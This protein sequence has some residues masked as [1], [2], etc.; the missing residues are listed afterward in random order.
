MSLE[1]LHMSG[2]KRVVH[3]R[4]PGVPFRQN[5]CFGT[6]CPGGV[7]FYIDSRTCD[8]ESVP[9]ESFIIIILFRSYYLSCANAFGFLNEELFF[10]HGVALEAE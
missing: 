1:Y 8:I 10:W 4:P 9:I 7:L 5:L 2:S 6:D 3:E